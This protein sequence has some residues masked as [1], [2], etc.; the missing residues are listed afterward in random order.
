[1]ETFIFEGTKV[2]K[3]ILPAIK[4]ID[5]GTF[6]SLNTLQEVLFVA[7]ESGGLDLPENLFGDQPLI[8]N[9]SPELLAIA[10]EMWRGAMYAFE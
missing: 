9:Y 10:A 7:S 1:M 3:L 2:E 6:G 4:D 8:V 5:Q